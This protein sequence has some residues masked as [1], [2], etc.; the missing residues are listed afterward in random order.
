MRENITSV[1]CKIA[2]PGQHHSKYL[3]VEQTALTICS[4]LQLEMTILFT[5][6]S[7][8]AGSHYVSDDT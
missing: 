4:T 6:S 5:E 7:L 8:E 1:Q 2:S 3:D